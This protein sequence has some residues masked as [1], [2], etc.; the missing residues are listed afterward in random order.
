MHTGGVPGAVSD[1]PHGTGSWEGPSGD[2]QWAMYSPC[3]RTGE[4]RVVPVAG[5][6]RNTVI[7]VHTSS[8]PCTQVAYLVQ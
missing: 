8:V 2:H 1:M 4:A 7:P 5:N 6:T 3:V